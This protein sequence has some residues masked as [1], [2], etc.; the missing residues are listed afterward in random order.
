MNRLECLFSSQQV[1]VTRFDHQPE[2]FHLDPEEEVCR[3]YA[4][5]FVEAGSFRLETQRGSWLLSPGAAFVSRPGA[6]HGYRHEENRPS[7]VC[8]SVRFSHGF[9]MGMRGIDDPL[10]P[11]LPDAL[12]PTNRLSFLRLRLTKLASVADG[13]ALE[14]LACELISAV[15][16]GGD[17]GRLY[18]VSQLKWYAERV[19][20]V[21]ETLQALYWEQHSLAS[22]AASV[23]MSTFQFARV[24]C[25]LT[26]YPPHKYLLKVR[27]ERASSMLLDGKSV[28][29]TCFEVGFSNLSHF[30]RSFRRQFG[31]APSSFKSRGIS[32]ARI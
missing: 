20:A 29:E 32:Q 21:R 30:T 6:V 17:C 14:S 19:E 3:D 5:H 24:F 25:E 2:S 31:C 16:S 11:D 26:G 22:L 12:T 15:R 23:G 13:L 10:P 28:T 1:S 18:R 27:L 7:D 8:V 4:I 9:F